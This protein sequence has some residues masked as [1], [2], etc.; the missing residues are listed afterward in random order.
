MLRIFVVS[1]NGVPPAAPLSAVFGEGLGCIGREETNALALPDPHKHISRVQ[2]QVKCLSGEYFLVDQGGN[3]TSVNGRP[4][5]KGNVATLHDGDRIEMAEWVLRVETVRPAPVFSAAPASAATDDPLG[6]LGAAAP[7]AADPLAALLGTPAAAA[8][9]A[10]MSSAPVPSTPMPAPA[11]RKASDDP[12][13]IFS[14]V[15]VPAAQERPAVAAEG[16]DPFAAFGTPAAAPRQPAA[17]QASADDPL[18]LGIA[19]AATGSVDSLFGL[20]GKAASDPFANS[21]LADPLMQAPLAAD[22]ADPLALLM[23]GGAAPAAPVGR[24]DS[25]LLNDAFVPPQAQPDAAD[26]F[27]F[28]LP[29]QMVVGTPDNPAPAVAPVVSWGRESA[30]VIDSPSAPKAASGVAMQ[31]PPVARP[32]AVNSAARVSVE[33]LQ[34]PLSSTP[35]AAGPAGQSAELLAAFIRGLG[36]PGLNP[37]GGLTPELAEHIGVMLRESVQGTVELLVARAATKREVRAE[38][39]MIVSKN[40]NPLKFSPDVNFAL[41]QL[42]QPQ[43]SK[44]FMAPVEAMR[45]AYDDL[46]AH[47]IGFIAGMRAALAG[48][49]GRFRPAEL[50]NRLSDKSFLDS[51]LPANRKAKLWDLY[52]QRYSDILSEAEDDFHSLF[53]RE[54]L[55]AYEEQIDRLSNDRAPGQ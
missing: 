6:L 24:N 55:R 37:P 13:A 49:L 1:L 14:A 30:P 20:E 53:G 17:V 42:L 10:A 41:H 48:I 36:V 31:P 11:S 35:P 21:A 45:D 29:T 52:E 12:F 26:E 22:G 2:A 25:P 4:L 34:T 7:T 28:N 16:M 9:V 40:N 32:A 46:R 33:A 8:P 3:P 44:G 47:Q 54:F 18:G 50:E 5:G 39:T 27:D 38:M 51:V 23:G 43:G 19:P 15:A